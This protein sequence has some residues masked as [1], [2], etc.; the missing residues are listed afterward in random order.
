MEVVQTVKRENVALA[1]LSGLSSGSVGGR[2]KKRSC[3]SQDGR[4]KFIVNLTLQNLASL[5]RLRGSM[6][7]P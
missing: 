6:A 5:G 2:Q 1:D 4:S 7:R 3:L